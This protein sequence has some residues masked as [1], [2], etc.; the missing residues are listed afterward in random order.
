MANRPVPFT[1][2]ATLLPHYQGPQPT[3]TT[4]YP[5]N[6]N[7]FPRFTLYSFH[8]FGLLQH[9]RPSFRQAR[10]TPAQ[11]FPFPH[12]PGCLPRGIHIHFHDSGRS[13]YCIQGALPDILP[14]PPAPCLASVATARCRCKTGP[15]PCL[16]LLPHTLALHSK[17]ILTSR[18]YVFTPHLVNMCQQPASERLHWHHC[19]A[20]T[21]FHV[22][23]QRQRQS[24]SFEPR[25]NTRSTRRIRST[26]RR[27]GH[28]FSTLNI[29]HL[30]CCLYVCLTP[31]LTQTTCIFCC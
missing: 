2:Q 23:R 29:F 28:C 16:P 31:S 21:P 15:G 13:L 14:S 27:H 7:S 10:S 19:T 30:T 12:E 11:H 24:S 25:L 22:F 3:P 20:Y 17:I 26:R 1:Q 5:P 9:F 4:V 8:R 18:V 6:D